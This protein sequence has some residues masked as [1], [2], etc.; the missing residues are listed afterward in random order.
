MEQW[1]RILENDGFQELLKMQFSD[2]RDEPT[3]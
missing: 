1:L 2:E 3:F